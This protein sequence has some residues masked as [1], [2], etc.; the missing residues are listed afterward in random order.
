MELRLYF[1]S[2]PP[3]PRQN[4][5]H[6]FTSYYSQSITMYVSLQVEKQSQVHIQ[7]STKNIKRVW[8]LY[9]E[10]FHINP[11]Y[12]KRNTGPRTLAVN[13]TC[14]YVTPSF[15]S[16]KPAGTS[17]SVSCLEHVSCCSTNSQV[18]GS[19]LKKDKRQYGYRKLQ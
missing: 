19:K 17:R 4:Q 7:V 1:L 6:F 12:Q 9:F 18:S 13:L 3:C 14:S 16:P 11:F 10:L 15:T 2:M 5:P 8:A